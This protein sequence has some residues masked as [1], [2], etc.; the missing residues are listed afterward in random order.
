MVEKSN[1]GIPGEWLFRIDSEQIYLCGAGF[2]GLE[3]VDSCSPNEWYLDCSRG[4]H[5]KGGV[6]CNTETGQ[7]PSGECS[8]GWTNGPTCDIDID[9]CID[10]N[11]LCPEEQPDCVNTAG[12][13]LCLCFEYDN[14][15]N[16]CRGSQGVHRSSSEQ[17]PVRVMPLVPQIPQTPS[18]RSP[19]RHRE[20][21]LSSFN[22]D[23]PSSTTARETSP[24]ILMH[25][26]HPLT[27]QPILGTRPKPSSVLS[28]PTTTFCPNCDPN[29]HCEDG[30]CVCNF[31]W[32][33]NGFDCVDVDECLQSG[34]CG[35]NAVCQ[36]SLGS[37]QCVCDVGYVASKNG[38]ED[39]DEC[40]E[41]LVTCRGGITSHC[42]NTQGGF[43]CDCVA[44]Y[45][46]SPDAPEGCQ[47]NS[48]YVVLLF[49]FRCE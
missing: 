5:C 13:Y 30:K 16:S 31:G 44:G 19:A 12:S 32:S 6:A 48:Y 21:T 49:I 9:E 10:G 20:S 1:I 8:P 43:K 35:A 46:G 22:I 3:C 23:L 36:N 24:T 34:I 28:T 4:C 33:G 45:I 38:C 15:T 39:L 29:G 26:P 17:I 37:Y 18:T 2:K 40:A 42:V 14:R 11:R 47:G 7:C 41:G 27:I 25:T